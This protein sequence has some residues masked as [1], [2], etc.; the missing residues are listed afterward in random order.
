MVHVVTGRAASSPAG[1]HGGT[2]GGGGGVSDVVV[3]VVAVVVVEPDPL[4]PVPA[5]G[6]GQ[7]AHVN[8]TQITTTSR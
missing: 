5:S 4:C 6:R 1:M 3:V 7:P 8:A 2:A